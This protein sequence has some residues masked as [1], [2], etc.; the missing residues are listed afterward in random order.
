MS[1]LLTDLLGEAD[2]VGGQIINAQDDRLSDII[3]DAV[4]EFSEITKKILATCEA[5][6]DQVQEVIDIFLTPLRDGQDVPRVYIEGLVQCLQTKS[7]IS[8]TAVR[9]LDAKTRLLQAMKAGTILINNNSVGGDGSELVSIL[10][11]ARIDD[12]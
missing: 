5:D 10:N 4:D 2:G 8:L 6:R 11:D 12:A 1:K 7:T 9:L 3:P